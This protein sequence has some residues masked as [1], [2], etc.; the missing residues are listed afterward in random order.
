MRAMIGRR[1]MLTGTGLALAFSPASTRQAFAQDFLRHGGDPQKLRR[2]PPSSIGSS[3]RRRR[4]SCEA[5]S[6]RRRW[7]R[8]APV[9][10]GGLVK[11]QAHVHAGGAPEGLSGGHRHRRPPVRR[12]RASASVA[13]VPGMQWV[14]GAMGQAT[15]TGVRLRDILGR[16]RRAPEGGRP[17]HCSAP[18]RPPKPT[19][20]AFLR[21][22]PMERALDPST[23]VAWR[24]NGE[25]SRSRTARRCASSCRDGRAT[26]G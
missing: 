11:T 24:M 12:Q 7:I 25:D 2:R 20:P 8:V 15:F 22:I 9:E 14:H 4:S 26:T 18:T 6:A 5:I 16:R 19:E 13:A 1:R 23:L 10:V 21:S 17:R 3:S